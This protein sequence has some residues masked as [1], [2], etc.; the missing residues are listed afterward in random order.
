LL[1]TGYK[2]NKVGLA[3]R[4]KSV[5]GIVYLDEFLAKMLVRHTNT[6]LL[7]KFVTQVQIRELQKNGVSQR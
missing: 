4:R 7:Q 2:N 1:L 5:Y 3:T 6:P